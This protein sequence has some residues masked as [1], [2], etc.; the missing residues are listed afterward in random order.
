M[1]PESNT[2]GADQP[3][4][5]A[6]AADPDRSDAASASAIIVAVSVLQQ[7]R[8]PVGILR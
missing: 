2:A 4:E 5:G 7:R 1:L 8:M 6:A 3:S